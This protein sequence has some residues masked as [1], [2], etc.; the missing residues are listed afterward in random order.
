MST[1]VKQNSYMR[2]KGLYEEIWEEVSAVSSRYE[3]AN[4]DEIDEDIRDEL[5]EEINE[6]IIVLLPKLYELKAKLDFIVVDTNTTAKA[7]VKYEKYLDDIT[8]GI[9]YFV[10]VKEDIGISW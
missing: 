6:E 8:N 10:Y 3:N 9:N 4:N 2:I 1:T 7:K 5:H